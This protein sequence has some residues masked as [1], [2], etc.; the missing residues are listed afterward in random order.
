[1]AKASDNVFPYVHIA[2][3]AAP[4]SPASGSQRLFLDSA[5]GNKLKRKDSAGVVTAIEGAAGGTWT[6]WTPALTAA[7]TNPTLG[8]GSSVDGRYFQIG[9]LVIASFTIQFGTSGFSAGSG[10]YR[11]S[12]PVAADTTNLTAGAPMGFASGFNPKGAYSAM[13]VSSTTVRF[14]IETAGTYLSS[15]TSG[16]GADTW[17]SG[18]Q[19]WGVLT[20]EA[21]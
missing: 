6:S 10:E 15:T 3:A 13:R 2:P 5:D 20:Y 4:A 8:T 9:K 11:V 1:M 17:G 21:A 14:W 19:L 18:S 16:G 7:T 12:L